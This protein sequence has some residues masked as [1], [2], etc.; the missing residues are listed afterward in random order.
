MN[1]QKTINISVRNDTRAARLTRREDWLLGP[2]APKRDV[3]TT[4][5]TYGALDARRLRGVE[6]PKNQGKDWGIVEGDR[7]VIVLDGHRER[8]KIGKVREVRKDAE[9]CFVTGLNR[10]C[11]H[12]LYA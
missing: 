5:D 7:V 6:K 4:K 2:L 10:V 11:H 1:E 3:G 9:E 12:D 8:G